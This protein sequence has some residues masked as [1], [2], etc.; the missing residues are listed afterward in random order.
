[1]QRVEPS[2]TG[3]GRPPPWSAPGA[4]WTRPHRAT[5]GCWAGILA[6]SFAADTD[7]VARAT[8]AWRVRG[9]RVADAAPSPLELTEDQGGGGLVGL[10]DDLEL[11]PSRT[12]RR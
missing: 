7:P 12:N 1:V 6:D 9:R 11:C 4:G 10:L 5:T 3:R 2:R 8:E